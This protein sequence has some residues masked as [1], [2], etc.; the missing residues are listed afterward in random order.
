MIGELFCEVCFVCEVEIKAKKIATLLGGY[1]RLCRHRPIFPSGFPLS[2]F[3]AVELNY[4]VRDGNG[5]TLNAINTDCE[6]LF[7]LRRTLTIITEK[8]RKSTL[9]LKKIKKKI[10]VLK[11]QYLLLKF[12]QLFSNIML[13]ITIK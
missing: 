3:G 12:V 2:I 10:M 8:T 7:V 13:I 1:F 4:R 9:F 11:L 5:W 6:E